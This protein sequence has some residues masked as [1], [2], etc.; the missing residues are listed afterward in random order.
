MP[1]AST[2]RWS[3]MADR[4]QDIDALLAR[5]NDDFAKIERE[6][7]EALQVQEVSADLRIDIKNFCENLRSVLDYLAHEIR[8]KY[9]PSAS[10]KDR[11][12]FPILPDH[13]TFE[14]KMCN[15]FPGLKV[16][17]S[18]LWDYLEAIQP[19]HSDSAWLG[20]F[21]RLNNENK[22]GCLVQQTRSE[23]QEVRVTTQGGGRVSWN[24]Q[25]VR[26]GPGVR[27]GGVPVDPRTQLPVPH[28]PQKVERITW[29]D[30]RFEGIN[31]SALQLLTS[32]LE[33]IQQLSTR[34]FEWL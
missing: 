6:Y 19:Y 16:C 26:F 14:S 7:N 8:E 22:H 5:S 25:S 24:P 30:F 10:P 21:N 9:C 12:Y 3:D 34:A 33:G 15:W 11:F 29:V 20:Y 27:I 23:R 28:P 13:S 31:V 18:D 17:C 32:T 1:L 4:K 2:E